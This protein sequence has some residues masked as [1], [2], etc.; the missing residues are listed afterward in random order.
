MCRVLPFDSMFPDDDDA[1]SQLSQPHM[2]PERVVINLE[3]RLRAALVSNDDLEET[4]R[5]SHSCT[6]NLNCQAWKALIMSLLL[7]PQLKANKADMVNCQAELAATKMRLARSEADFE[8]IGH[9]LAW[10]RQRE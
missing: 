6:V 7:L 10:M 8:R 4:V 2:Y 1:R 9:S 5:G 3:E